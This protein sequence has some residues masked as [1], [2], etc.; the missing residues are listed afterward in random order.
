L[1]PPQSELVG[2]SGSVAPLAIFALVVR[3]RLRVTGWLF[4]DGRIITI[5]EKA[6]CHLALELPNHA[7]L[8]AE[9]HRGFFKGFHPFTS[10]RTSGSSIL[11]CNSEYELAKIASGGFGRTPI[12]PNCPQQ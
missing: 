2:T 5:S 4:A 1:A 9:L 6:S 3:F 7:I 8:K 11:C 10:D 12:H